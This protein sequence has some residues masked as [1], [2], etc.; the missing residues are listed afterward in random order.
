M[1]LKVPSSATIVLSLL[2]GVLAVLNQTVLH[3]GS[4]W[5]TY[6]TVGLVFLAGLGISPLVGKQFRSALH[7]SHQV[8]VIISAALSAAALVLTTINVSSGLKAI[9]GGVLT[10]LAGIG[11]A[12]IAPAPTPKPASAVTPGPPSAGSGT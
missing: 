6:I 7:P 3:L 10:F 1:T 5:S 2:G 12:P 11:F 8:S 9:L 4:H